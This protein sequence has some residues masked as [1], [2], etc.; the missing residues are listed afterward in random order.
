[1]NLNKTLNSITKNN[2]LR[3]FFIITWIALAIV[4]SSENIM[5]K[6]HRDGLLSI[7]FGLGMLIWYR[8]NGIKIVLKRDLFHKKTDY[9]YRRDIKSAQIGSIIGGII[10]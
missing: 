3:I 6:N 8:L 7:T 9:E 4:L 5:L 10:F 1:M 2:S